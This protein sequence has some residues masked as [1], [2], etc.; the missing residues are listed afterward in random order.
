MSNLASIQVALSLSGPGL[1]ECLTASSADTLT[2]TSFVK[3]EPVIGTTET[4]IV[5][6]GISTP[7]WVLVNNL[8]GANY[9]ELTCVSGVY[10]T[11]RVPPGRPALF[12]MDGAS[13]YGKANTASVQLEVFALPQ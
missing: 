13:L 8:D 11:V 9:V 10:G 3:S 6:P 2:G 7:G 12:F 5:L 1:Q 4:A